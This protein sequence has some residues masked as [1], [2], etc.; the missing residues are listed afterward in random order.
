[1]IGQEIFYRNLPESF[2]GL[3]RSTDVAACGMVDEHR[4]DYVFVK[5]MVF[6]PK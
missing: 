6:Q 4:V 2:E 5:A 1:M 3:T